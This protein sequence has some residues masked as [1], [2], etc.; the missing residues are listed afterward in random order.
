[1]IAK[2]VYILLLCYGSLWT[3]FNFTTLALLRQSPLFYRLNYISKNYGNIFKFML[4]V[5]VSVAKIMYT[6]PF[7]RTHCTLR[8]II[9]KVLHVDT[10]NK[11]LRGLKR[12][13]SCSSNSSAS[14]SQKNYP[15][16]R[17][18]VSTRWF[19]TKVCLFW[20]VYHSMRIRKLGMFK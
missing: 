20:D 5:R 6:N 18:S 16:Q 14:S 17:K 19:S 8:Q 12:S 13:E 11:N 4:S 2:K 1:M 3:S 15:S 10:K 7:N 9:D